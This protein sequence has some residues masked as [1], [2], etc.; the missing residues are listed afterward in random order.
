MADAP[1]IRENLGD[2]WNIM[3]W[4]TYLDFVTVLWEMDMQQMIF[5]M[6]QH[7]RDEELLTA[8]MKDLIVASRLPGMFRAMLAL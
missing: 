2:F 1:L 5:T 6:Q 7:Y 3:E 8:C 4:E